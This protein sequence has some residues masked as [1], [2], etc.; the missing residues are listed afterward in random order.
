MH[1]NEIEHGVVNSEIML[2][3][4]SPGEVV[5]IITKESADAL[6]LSQRKN[7]YVVIKASSV[8]VGVD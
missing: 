4:T 1:K 3:I 7:I 5:S 2:E 6:G 8:M